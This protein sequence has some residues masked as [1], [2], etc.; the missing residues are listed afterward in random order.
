[1]TNQSGQIMK[2]REEEDKC[3]KIKE[4][5]GSTQS[6]TPVLPVMDPL[7]INSLE[8]F[9]TNLSFREFEPDL[10]DDYVFTEE[11]TKTELLDCS[12]LVVQTYLRFLKNMLS[13]NFETIEKI[14]KMELCFGK[15]LQKIE[16]LIGDTSSNRDELYKIVSLSLIKE[17]RE[18][19]NTTLGENVKPDREK[20]VAEYNQ[21][22][23]D[24]LA[25]LIDMVNQR[26][27]TLEPNEC[28]S[29]VETL[30]NSNVDDCLLLGELSSQ[31]LSLIKARNGVFSPPDLETTK[32]ALSNLNVEVLKKDIKNL[33]SYVATLYCLSNI[34]HL[35][36]PM[37]VYDAY[38]ESEVI[39]RNDMT[40]L[41][42]QNLKN[43]LNIDM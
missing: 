5:S 17:K 18:L 23:Q 1:M 14:T 40:K 3:D 11:T 43:L 29:I 2:N 7:R 27:V 37:P 35:F 42:Q 26:K 10:V 36:S 39:V 32:E 30:N 19:C 12:K 15:I 20:I 34:D 25:I 41:A 28:Y 16:K 22:C 21:D 38:M 33:L 9:L 4:E 31:G 24:R 13:N 6:L 8:K